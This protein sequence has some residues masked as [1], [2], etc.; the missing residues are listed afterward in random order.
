MNTYQSQQFWNDINSVIGF[1][2]SVMLMVFV[3][4]MVRP[5]GKFIEPPLKPEK[6]LPKPIV[7]EVAVP[8][9]SYW[10]C[11]SCGK[12]LLPGTRVF[13][14]GKEVYCSI[15]CIRLP[16]HHSTNDIRN[17]DIYGE[18]PTWAKELVYSAT[19]WWKEQTK[20][21]TPE[22]ELWWIKGEEYRVS[23]GGEAYIEENS[24][25]IVEGPDLDDTKFALLHELAHIFSKEPHHVDY[26]WDVVMKLYQWVGFSSSQVF[27]LGYPRGYS[28]EI[29]AALERLES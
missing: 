22:P 4:G 13:K 23:T 12:E 28:D 3:V 5:M 16:E 19:E 1:T 11:I 6:H 15:P 26:F 21:F 20:E 18:A 14:A 24:I 29:D 7:K 10:S 8:G 25:T 9:G 2:M 27:R 17:P